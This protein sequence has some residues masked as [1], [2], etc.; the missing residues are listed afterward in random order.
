MGQVLT[1]ATGAA[2]AVGVFFALTG[3]VGI[4]RFPDFF[5]RVQAST[6][7]TTLGALGVV[8]AGVLCC[9]AGGAP[10]IWYVKLVVIGLL[11]FISSAMAGH[12]LARAS[13][14]R[15]HRPGAGFE[16]DDYKEDGLD[17]L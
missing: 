8:V 11:L 1:V 12:A 15:G 10:A 9:A 2:L 6:C 7:I 4:L 5:G 14:R 16:K 3:V 17:E 13:H